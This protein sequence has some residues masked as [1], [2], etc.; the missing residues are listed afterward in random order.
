MN[1]SSAVSAS[2]KLHVH[3]CAISGYGV[4]LTDCMVASLC[5][6]NGIAFTDS[7]IASFYC[8]TIMI[9]IALWYYNFTQVCCM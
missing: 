5:L 2:I 4:A 1:H 6:V 7:M 3:M 8:S 9:F